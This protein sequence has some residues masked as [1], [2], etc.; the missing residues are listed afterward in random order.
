MKSLLAEPLHWGRVEKGE[1]KINQKLERD[2]KS[3]P[4]QTP[5]HSW[6]RHPL[7]PLPILAS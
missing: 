6:L 7:L 4:T 3:E 2:L 5:Q 1:R